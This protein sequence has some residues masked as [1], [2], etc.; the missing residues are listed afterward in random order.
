[1]RSTAGTSVLWDRVGDVCTLRVLG[2][3]S[4]CELSC[5]RDRVVIATA[6]P[7]TSGA[8]GLVGVV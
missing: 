7:R 1:M 3:D 4:W 6:N 2:G 5:V 8:R